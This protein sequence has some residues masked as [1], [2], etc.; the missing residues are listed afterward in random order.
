MQNKQNTKRDWNT[1]A[2]I[3]ITNKT[4][5]F[6]ELSVVQDFSQ[7]LEFKKTYFYWKRKRLI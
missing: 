7:N 3:R 6:H 4:L 2:H 5:M 1:E